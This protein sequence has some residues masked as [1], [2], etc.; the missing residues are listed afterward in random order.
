[1]G[2]FSERN[3]FIVAQVGASDDREAGRMNCIQNYYPR[4]KSIRLII[5]KGIIC[6][7]VRIIVLSALTTFQK[8][9]FSLEFPEILGQ[10]LICYNCLSAPGNFDIMHC[11]ILNS[12][13]SF[14]CCYRVMK[15]ILHQYVVI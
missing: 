9:D 10:Y 8:C 1:M 2:F 3:Y 11:G 14:G 12:L 13:L 4:N 15:L 5:N 7:V 6:L